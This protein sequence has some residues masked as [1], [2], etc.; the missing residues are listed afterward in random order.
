MA[1][2]SGQLGE[3]TFDE[4][5]DEAQDEIKALPTW[6]QAMEHAAKFWRKA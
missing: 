3:H 5:Y 6:L 1:L 2:I 4:V